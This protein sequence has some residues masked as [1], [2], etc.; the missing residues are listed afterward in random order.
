MLA[1][2]M[3][4]IETTVHSLPGDLLSGWTT[5]ENSLEIVHHGKIDMGFCVC[6]QLCL[7]IALCY[8]QICKSVQFQ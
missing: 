5:G 6:K 2:L 7:I 8:N 3:G 1:L 4:G